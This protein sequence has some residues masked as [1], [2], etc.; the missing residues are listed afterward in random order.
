MDFTRFSKTHILLKILICKEVPG[1]FEILQ[2]YPRFT[3]GLQEDLGSRNVALGVRPTAVRWNS[4]EPSPE[5]A[6]EGAGEDHMLERESLVAEVRSAHAGGEL[7]GGDRRRPLQ[8]L[9]SREEVGSAGQPA[10]LEAGVEGHGGQ[11][12]HK[13]SSCGLEGKL[14]VV[15]SMANGGGIEWP[16][17]QL[18]HARGRARQ[19]LL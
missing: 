16:A 9:R 11:G 15:V 2:L 6:G 10:T 12:V 3:D 18:W 4:S 14:A 1:G 13:R 7:G 8:G 19:P 5:W 17:G